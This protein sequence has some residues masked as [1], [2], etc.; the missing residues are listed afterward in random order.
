VIL[1]IKVHPGAGRNRIDGW[2]GDTLK[3][4]V[5]EPPEKGRANRAVLSLL[6]ET[7]GVPRGSLRII[8][9]EGSRMKHVEVIGMDPADARLRLG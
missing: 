2:L 6:A 7:L 8:R 4:S 5:S 1:K 9:G 3:V